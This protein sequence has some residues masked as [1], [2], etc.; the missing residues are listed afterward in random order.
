M[1]ARHYSN[2]QNLVISFEYSWFLAKNLPNFVSLPWKLHNRK[3]HNMYYVCMCKIFGHFWGGRGQ[4][5]MGWNCFVIY[6]WPYHQ[7]L[8]KKEKKKYLYLLIA[9]SSNSITLYS[10]SLCTSWA[11]SYFFVTEFEILVCFWAS[12]E[13]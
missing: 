9:G 8:R 13:V 12:W 1:T 2:S 5:W 11:G 3:C 7:E 6:G 10:N 4:K